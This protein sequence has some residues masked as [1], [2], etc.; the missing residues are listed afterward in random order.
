VR[1]LVLPTDYDWYTFLKRR[2]PLSEVNF[3]QPS[4][5]TTFHATQPGSP[6]FFKLKAPHNAIG[7]FGFFARA[8]VLP[9]WLAW[10]SF[11][12]DNGAATLDEMNLRIEK[13]RS[14]ERRDRSGRYEIGCLMI[15]SPVF[16]DEGNWVR[17]P[18][19]W[20][21]QIVSGRGQDVTAGDGAR[22]L[23]ECMERLEA[24]DFAVHEEMTVPQTD[25]ARFGAPV[26]ITPRL[27]QGTFRMAVTSAYGRACAVTNEHSL[28]VLEAAHIRPYSREGVH[29]VSNGLLLRSD[30]H[31][32]FDKGYVTVTSKLRFDVS[33]RL[34]EDYSNGK[35]YFPLRGLEISV[36]VRTQDKPDPEALRW[37]NEE[38]F[39]G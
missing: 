4:G 2:Q 26:L 13:Y 24:C 25:A 22:I 3:W 30:I 31:R 34:R 12:A 28:P 35:S 27:G 8:S 16:F 33:D 1:G 36:P 5:G 15:S 18:L 9:A 20:K 38:V 37:H 11:G 32:L 10:D 6:V 14:V 29:A 7:G 21:A 23:H 17:Q 19:D 39:L